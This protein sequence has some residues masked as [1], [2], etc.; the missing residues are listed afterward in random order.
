MSD[1]AAAGTAEPARAAAVAAKAPETAA[2]PPKVMDI[3]APETPQEEP[4]RIE[5]LPGVHLDINIGGSLVLHFPS[6]GKKYEGKVVGYEP[7]A[8]IIV[9][10][11]LPQDVLA[12]AAAG[13]GLVVQHAAG[14]MVFG[15]RSEILKHVTSPAALLFLGF[16]DTVDRIMLRH[17]ERVHVNLPGNLNGKYGEQ[18]VMVQDLTLT[19]C[20]FTAKVDLKT[21]LREA[22]VGDRLVLTC[23]MGCTLPIIAPVELRRVEAEKGL[24]HIGAQF[25]ELPPDTVE[26]LQGFIG[27]L[28]EFLDR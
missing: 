21:P 22:Q 5:R 20:Q 11:R 23:E 6:L 3:P 16:P 12:Q 2:R 24:L 15:F 7:Y 25:V 4:R 27:G 9:L 10:A 18:K 17:N 8:F 13:A 14:G 19:G 26:Q 28:L 1:Q